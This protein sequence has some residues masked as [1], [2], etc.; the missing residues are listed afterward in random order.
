M[1]RIYNKKPDGDLY[2]MDQWTDAKNLYLFYDDG[3]GVWCKDGLESD[4]CAFTTPQND[5][6]HV[7]WY[8]K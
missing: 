6:T 3:D 1:S 4:C 5:A 2:T 7:V 8:N